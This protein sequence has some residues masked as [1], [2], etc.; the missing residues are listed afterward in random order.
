MSFFKDFIDFL[1]KAFT[2]WIVVMP[3]EQGIRV[4]WGRKTKLMTKGVY[5]KVPI[6]HTVYVQE[7]RLRVVTMP[8]QTLSTKDG[9]AVTISCSVGY[10]ISDIIKLYNTLY[11]PDL[12]IMNICAG[13]IS[14]FI[15]S[16]KLEECLPDA[17]ETYVSGTLVK[18]NYGLEF[19][20]IK[21]INY[22]S[23]KTYRLIQ[24]HTNLWEGLDLLTKK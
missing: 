6:L 5:L 20:N 1:Q 2:W 8:I 19:D 24:D 12:T 23:V 3:W 16:R 17:I 22:A 9:F 18:T 4:T 14:E 15:C 10:S 21:V 13:K 11:Q 7:K